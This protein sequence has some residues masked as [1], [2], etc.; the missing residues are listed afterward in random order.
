M[1]FKKILKNKNYVSNYAL[2]SE[3][4]DFQEILTLAWG[5]DFV[6]FLL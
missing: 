1:I 6:G 3:F 5:S 4:S 2:N